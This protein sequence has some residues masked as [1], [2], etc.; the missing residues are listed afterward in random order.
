VRRKE[1]QFVGWAFL[2]AVVVCVVVT[3][4]SI[5][6]LLQFAGV[7]LR[8]FRLTYGAKSTILFALVLVANIKLV[9]SCVV[10]WRRWRL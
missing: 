2:G 5:L 3:T 4:V 8:Y 7:E 1:R 9:H 10:L 6:G